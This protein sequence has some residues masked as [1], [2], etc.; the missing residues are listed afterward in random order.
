MKSGFE[1]LHELVEYCL[2][3]TCIYQI[4]ICTLDTYIYILYNE[5]PYPLCTLKIKKI[6]LNI[7]KYSQCKITLSST[8]S[9]F[10][11]PWLVPGSFCIASPFLF[12][13]SILNAPVFKMKNDGLLKYAVD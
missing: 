1:M 10:E 11:P 2:T 6:Q 5:I 9:F 13:I 4:L 8:R 12:K 3:T 7:M